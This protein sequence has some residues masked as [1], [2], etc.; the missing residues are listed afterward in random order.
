MRQLRVLLSLVS[1][2]I[3]SSFMEVHLGIATTGYLKMGL[4]FEV[5]MICMFLNKGSYYF[6]SNR[7]S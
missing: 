1:Y 3:K 2:L 4:L 7:I 5:K 6:S